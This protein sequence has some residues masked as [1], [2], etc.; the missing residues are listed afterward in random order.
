MKIEACLL[1]WAFHGRGLDVGEALW[2]GVFHAVAAFCHAGFS[3]WPD[4]LVSFQSDGLAP[5]STLLSGSA[6]DRGVHT[7]VQVRLS[8]A[9][10]LGIVW[11]R[12]RST[13]GI[14]PLFVAPTAA[15]EP[16][17]HQRPAGHRG[18]NCVTSR[19]TGRD[20]VDGVRSWREGDELTAVH[21][22]AAAKTT[23]GARPS[24]PW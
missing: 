15:L 2:A 20:E 23:S 19:A 21:W 9:G 24:T 14:E 3:L 1:A 13:I 8:S 5:G 22:P 4:S 7:S 11:W 10:T 16:A 17:P 18:D 12:R 6:P